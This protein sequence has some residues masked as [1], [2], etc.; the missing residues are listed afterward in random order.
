MS[1]GRAGAEPRGIA[2]LAAEL[3]A[4][5]A[6]ASFLTRLPLED[7]D[8]PAA[9]GV[10]RGCWA[11]PLIGAAVG[12]LTAAVAVAADGA[13][14]PLAA[15]SLA[16]AAG[17]LLTGALHLDG[18]ADSA[19]SLGGGSRERALEIMR[20]HS[21][22]AYGAAAIALGLI[23]RTALVSALLETSDALTPLIVAGA[24]SRAA[25]L[26]LAF[27]L[28][29]AR[30]VPGPGA[31]L[32]G[33]LGP[34]R[35]ALAIALAAGLA[36]ALAGTD[37]IVALALGAAVVLAVGRFARRRLGGVTGDVLGAT[38]ELVELAVLLALVALR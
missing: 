35:V 10:A 19:D 37:A 11:F 15:A 24:L 2:A 12:A 27:A 36:I 14:T 26:P 18:L 4:A 6:A 8:G 28:P 13:L 22:G 17:V 25:V 21:V 34:G 23:L 9:G 5:K 38:V 29:Y 1:A 20:D 30:A 33:G 3:G 31:A 7:R 32:S 16:A